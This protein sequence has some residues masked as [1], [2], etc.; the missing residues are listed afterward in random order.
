MKYKSCKMLAISKKIECV[1]EY[2]KHYDVT[3]KATKCIQATNEK[4]IL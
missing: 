2:F 3:S 4:K 1:Q